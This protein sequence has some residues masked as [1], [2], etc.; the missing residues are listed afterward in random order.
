MTARPP[1]VG[2]RST[3]R[4]NSQTTGA[5]MQ[6]RPLH[7]HSI[8]AQAGCRP[9]LSIKRAEWG[10]GGTLSRA[11]QR[12]AS[13]YS[14]LSA[15]R[16]FP[17]NPQPTA[18]APPFRR[19][20]EGVHLDPHRSGRYPGRKRVLGALLPRAWHSGTNPSISPSFSLRGGRSVVDIGVSPVDCAGFSGSE[21]WV[22]MALELGETVRI[23]LSTM[24]AV[25]ICG[26]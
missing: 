26:C 5:W 24:V 4:A 10:G 3:N 25:Q 2:R 1:T 19:H 12:K 18:A 11:T 7:L 13:S 14:P 6:K 20:H 9:D 23:W 15:T 8:E 21:W 22:E 17:P 16:S